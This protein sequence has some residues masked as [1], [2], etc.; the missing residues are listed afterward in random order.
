MVA[1]RIQ[2]LPS[3]VGGT[4]TVAGWLTGS[5]SSGKIAFLQL[6]DGTGFVQAVV[7]KNDVDEATFET[8]QDPGAGER[9]A[10]ARRGARRSARAERRRALRARPRRRARER[11]ATPSP[12][13]STGSSSS[14]STA[15]CT[16]ATARRG[17][18]CASA[19]SS[20]APSTISSPTAASSA[21][22]RRSSCRPP[23]RGPPTCSRSTCSTRRRRTCRSRGSSTPKP[24]R[25]R[26]AP[27][28]RWGRRSA[29]R[30]ARRAGTCSSSG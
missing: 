28:T 20:S 23:S 19:T 4:V 15:T 10:R 17:P 16:C 30:R 14:A 18:S 22:T 24:A 29:P 25:W 11:A 7:A 6:R 2:D 13:R 8:A 27:S 3:A 12:P 9:R 26:W 21:S 5:R 1:T